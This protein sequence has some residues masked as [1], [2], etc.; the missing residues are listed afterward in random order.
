M[1][2]RETEYSTHGRERLYKCRETNCDASFYYHGNT[3]RY[4]WFTTVVYATHSRENEFTTHSRETQI[5]THGKERLNKS[6]E[7]NCDASFFYHTSRKHHQVWI[8]CY[9]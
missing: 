5:S 9:P 2:E 3:I 1:V 4:G 7:T 6:R 8:V